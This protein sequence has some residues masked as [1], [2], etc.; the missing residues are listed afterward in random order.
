MSRD[1]NIQ[2]NLITLMK[3]FKNR[4]YHLSKY[5]LDNSAFTDSF[6]NKIKNSK[7]L[8]DLSNYDDKEYPSYF[9]NISQ[10]ED[11]YNSLLEQVK[12]LSTTK[13]NEELSKELNEKLIKLIENE[14]YEEAA[15]LRDF[16]IKNQIKKN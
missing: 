8:S 5:L 3:I 1:E 6:I 14:K 7:R 12:E 2:K 15:A 10:M 16:M 13:K 4:P 9:P 11:F